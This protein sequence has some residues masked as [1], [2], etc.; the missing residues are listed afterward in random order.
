MGMSVFDF[1]SYIDERAHNFTGREWIFEAIN[2]WLANPDGPRFFL[3]KGEPGSGKTALSARLSQFSLGR[4]PANELTHLTYNFLSA[5]HFCSARDTL[6]IDPIAFADSIA[7][8][9]ANRYPPYLKVLEDL[10]EDRQVQIVVR[11][12]VQEVVNGQV[13][14]VII[15][16]SAPSPE[17]AFNRVVREP[18][19]ALVREGLNEQVIIL[20]DALDEALNYSGMSNIVSLL[21]RTDSLSPRVRFLLTTRQEARVENE[22]RDVKE[23]S[24]SIPNDQRNQDDIRRYVK[25]QLQDDPE[26]ANKATQV[27]FVQVAEL[28]EMVPRRAEGNFLYVRFLLDDMAKGQRSLTELEGLPEGLDGLYF[29]SLNRVVKLGGRDWY[30]QY[31]PLM[32][33]LSVAQENLTLVQLQALTGLSRSSCIEYRRNLQQFIEEVKPPEEKEEQTTRYR[34]YHQSVSDFLCREFLSVENKQLENTFYLPADEWHKSL[35]ERCEQGNISTI[36]GDVKHDPVEQGRREYAR[37]YYV[38]HLYHAGVREWRRLFAVLDGASYGRAKVRYF[39]PSMRSYAQ[40]LD[41]G[42]QAAGWRGWDLEEGVGLLPYLWRYTLLRCS[43]A[44][45]ADNYPPVAFRVLMLL[46]REYEALDLAEL[47][48]DPERRIDALLVIAEE[49]AGRQQVQTL[50]RACEVARAIKD[51]MRRAE[52]MGSIA[53]ALAQAEQ[54]EQAE[55]VIRMIEDGDQR[56]WALSALAERLAFAKKWEQ[57]EVVIQI[58][59]SSLTK[60][61][62][63]SQA[64]ENFLKRENALYLLAVALVH[65]QQWDRAEAVIQTVDRYVH[66]IPLGDSDQKYRAWELLVIMLT[67]AQ[68]W[69]RAEAVIPMVKGSWQQAGVARILAEELAQTQQWGRAETVIQTIE[70]SKSRAE[71]LSTLAKELSQAEERKRAEPIWLEAQ[72]AIQ[73]IKESESRAEA[74]RTLAVAFVQTNQL[75]RAEKVWAE[76]QTTI[77]MIE[78]SDQRAWALMW[79]AVALVQTNQQE[80]AEPI[81][82]EAQAAIQ[83][84]EDSWSKANAIKALVQAFTVLQQWGRAEAV[85]QTIEE[86]RSRV[87]ALSALAVALA[88][89]QQLK[90][91]EVVWGKAQAAIQTIED[92]DQR[93][94]VFFVLARALAQARRWDQAEAVIQTIE[95][96]EQRAWASYIFARALAQAQQ[97]DRAEAVIQ[98]IEYSDRRD[99]ALESLAEAFVQ[100]QQW[101]RAK[102]TILSIGEDRRPF[103]QYR[104]AEALIQARQWGRAEVVIQTIEEDRGRGDEA[105]GVLPTPEW[106]R[107]KYQLVE[108]GR[109]KLLPMLRDALIRAQ[110]WDRAE[111]VIQATEQLWSRAEALS[112]LAVAL[113]QA[114]QP[115]RAKMIWSKALE[116]TQMIKKSEQRAWT[117]TRLAT[118]LVQAQQ[119]ERAEV[120][121]TEAQ[122]TIRVIE[123]NDQKAK[124]LGNLVVM[125]ARVQEQERAETMW[126]EAQAAIQLIEDNRSR[127]N[128]IRTLVNPLLEVQEWEW[129]RG[130]IQTIEQREQRAE[131]LSLLAVALARVGRLTQ[132][133]TVIEAIG[134]KGRAVRNDVM[135][136]TLKRLVRVHDWEQAR[137]AIQ[138]IEGSLP[139]IKALNELAEA[140]YKVQD[141]VQAQTVWEQAEGV[142]QTIGA[143]TRRAEAMILLAKSLAMTQLWER[144]EVA[145]GKAQAAIQ[146]IED[147]DQRTSALKSLIGTLIEAQELDRAEAVIQTIEENRSRS[148]SL[149]SLGEALVRA[150]KWDRAEAVVLSI[151]ENDQRT[152]ALKTLTGALGESSQRTLE[153]YEGEKALLIV[154]KYEHLLHLLQS[155]WSQAHTRATALEVLQLAEAVIP[156]KPEIG[157]SFW[158]AFTWTDTF[159][160]G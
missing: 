154:S 111:A 81:W 102:A 15:N 56:D 76:A 115:E 138:G 73:T 63:R 100:T 86:S 109:A 4:L 33:V 65:A 29:D 18:L 128:V 159:L 59:E 5:I 37:K 114:Q 78:K 28:V 143:S 13:I 105:E 12:N 25:G 49:Q 84:I 107:G 57:A 20:V 90:R 120:V 16:V 92:G 3:L 23:L 157:I 160:Q 122:A 32:G 141:W 44:S 144:A 133:K 53:S 89:A 31:A 30:S 106:E 10:R 158:E 61:E 27:G 62:T 54:W 155:I 68:M 98:T 8:Q 39:V 9:L 26:L 79:L 110:E 85:V 101:E 135:S 91:T 131:L 119:R 99:W 82:L 41:L 132:A 24:L 124:A 87:E 40:D 47:L 146:T 140:L 88:H 51:S 126:T 148:E 21:A 95:K 67:R 7:T 156:Y 136:E 137:V 19:E 123:E 139:K 151:E 93:A 64:I 72:A 125:L 147:V 134:G 149:K 117:L 74:L 116:T 83:M 77:Q 52:R 14:G 48:T 55:A 45:R 38:T 118:V 11:Q 94:E 71:A 142:A 42:R 35:A 69:D 80:R 46:K 50:L 103:S 129:V 104:L 70:E 153:V 17:T 152:S 36:W 96:N 66:H 145:W 97:W 75:E 22:F 2:D 34:L 121:W 6:W 130:V 108:Y 43:L 1:S 112:A 113:V 127:F 60:A 150:Q 58:V